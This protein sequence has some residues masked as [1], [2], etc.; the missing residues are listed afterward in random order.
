MYYAIA[1]ACAAAVVYAILAPRAKK[2]P[3]EIR[4]ATMLSYLIIPAAVLALLYA[5]VNHLL[6]QPGGV[7]ILRAEPTT[8]PIKERRIAE[9]MAE[10]KEKDGAADEY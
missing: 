9:P 7:S 1:I 4:H 2:D 6:P 10:S 3:I 5:T 8:E